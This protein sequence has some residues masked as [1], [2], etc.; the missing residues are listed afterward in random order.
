MEIWKNIIGYESKYQISNLGRVKSLERKVNCNKGFRIVKEKLLKQHL[1]NK[2]YKV[3]FGLRGK[4]FLVHRLV[5]INFLGLDSSREFVNHINGIKTDNRL[6]NL[7]WC[8]QS[9][10]QK[11]AY[12]IGLQKVSQINMDALKLKITKKI[13][14]LS[15]GKIYNSSM[16]LSS[17]I[18]LSR[19]YLTDMLNGSKKNTTTF[20][21][22]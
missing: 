12:K 19:R 8:T 18:N 1:V 10:N 22:L 9:E 14:D 5:A 2:Y 3:E 6:E 11:H 7:E 16:E 15:N 21:Y 4:S 17:K 20:K 13:I